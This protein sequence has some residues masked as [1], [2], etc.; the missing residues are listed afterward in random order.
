MSLVIVT[1]KIV[2]YST[3]GHLLNQLQNSALHIPLLSLITQDIFWIIIIA[4]EFL[5]RISY[6]SQLQVQ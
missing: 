4:Q 3:T 2:K 5:C 1:N 6:A